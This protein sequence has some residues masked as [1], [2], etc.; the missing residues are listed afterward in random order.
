MVDRPTLVIVGAGGLVGTLAVSLLSLRQFEW[1]E[2]RLLASPRSAGR[3][4][5]VRGRRQN[6]REVRPESFAGADVVVFATPAAAGRRWIPV[7]LDAGALVVDGSGA[8]GD[9]EAVP[10]IVPAVNSSLV[11]D[12]D[13]RLL[14]VPGGLT[15]NLAEAL[16]VIHSQ[17]G[18]EQVV[19]STYEPA[20]LMGTTGVDRLREELT[21]VMEEATGPAWLG[22]RPG[23]VRATVRTALGDEPSP[24]NA[25]L[26]LN[27]IPFAGTQEPDGSPSDE[28]S[29]LR[30]LPAVLGLPSLAMSITRVLVPVVSGHGASVHVA[31]EQRLTVNK[32]RQ[33]F[34]EAPDIVMVD[35]EHLDDVPTPADVAGTDPAFIGR[36]RQPPGRPCELD[37]FLVGDNVRRGTALALLKVAELAATRPGL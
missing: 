12:T 23:D 9:D 15:T 1:G 31:C 25:P 37:F 3:S 35:G 20:T 34:V 19:V 24:F 36:L 6:I 16:A 26:A 17:W 14:S 8:Y 27:V 13:A 11:T 7:A 22:Q 28:A 30:E 18:L 21:A 4:M 29:L 2:V 5:A 32:V 33:S 10:A